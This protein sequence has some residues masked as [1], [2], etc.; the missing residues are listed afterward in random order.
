MSAPIQHAS[1]FVG[2]FVAARSKTAET[3]MSA[4]GWIG[5]IVNANAVIVDSVF[6]YVFD[7]QTQWIWSCSVPRESFDSILKQ[8]ENIEDASAI[9]CCGRMI[10][11]CAVCTDPKKE[12]DLA[13]ALTMYISITKTF[14]LTDRANKANHFL[15]V[16]YGQT[17]TIRPFAMSGPSRYLLPSENIQESFKSVISMD[18]S[19]HPEWVSAS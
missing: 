13:I 11:E 6:F 5:T 14:Q 12:N 10:S 2:D 9:A 1:N 19:N 7:Y 4:T 17:N 8:C 16:R 18:L 3:V 15:V